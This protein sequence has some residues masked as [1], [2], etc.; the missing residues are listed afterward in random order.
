[1]LKKI[2]LLVAFTLQIVA[3][4]AQTVLRGGINDADTGEPLIGANLLVVGTGDGAVTDF[5]GQFELR[6][7][8]AFPFKLEIS[9]LGYTTQIIDVVNE[10]Q[11]NLTLAEDIETIGTVEITGQRIGEKQKASPRTVEQLDAIAIKQT[12]ASSFYDGLGALKGVDMT[13]ASLGFKVINTRGFNSTSPVRSLQIIDGVDNQAPGLNFSLGNFLGSSE[14]DVQSVDIIVGANSALYGPNAFNGVISITTKDPFYQQ[15]LSGMVKVAERNLF[16]AAVRF[17]DV[18]DNKDELPMIGYKLNFEYLRADDWVADNFDPVFDTNTDRTNPGGY[19]AVNIYGDEYRA[20]FDDSDSQPW[21]RPGL[22]Q[23]HR[24]GYREQDLVNYDTRNLKT[25][26]AVHFRLRPEQDFESPE[27]IA[28]AN[29]SNGTT[30]YQGDNRFS[31]Q[32]I[33]FF[34]SRLEL[35]KRD[36]YFVRA[37]YTVDDAGESFD[38][39]FT[40]LRLQQIAKSDRNWARDYSNYWTSEAEPEIRG[41]REPRFPLVGDY[42]ELEIIFEDG[43]VITSFDYDA[44][45][46]WLAMNNGSLALYHDQAEAAANSE[47]ANGDAF[48]EPD[49]E[50]FQMIFDSITGNLNNFEEMGTRF[51]DQSALYHTQGEYTF[52]PEWLDY[53][54]IGGNTRLYTPDS[55]GTVFSDTLDAEGNRT[56]ISVFEFGLYTGIEKKFADDKF[57]FSG[58]FRMDKNENFDAVFSPAASVVFKPKPN[59]YARLSFSS[60]VRNPTLADQYLLL[61]VGRATL[62]GNLTGVQDLVTVESFE[63][64]LEMP[65]TRRSQL[66]SFNIAPIQPEKVRTLELGYRTTIANRLFLDA[67]YYYSEYRDFLG[68]NIGVRVAF[69]ETTGNLSNARAFRYA[70]NSLNKVTTQGFS[71]GANY[72]FWDKYQFAANYSFNKLNDELDDPIIPAF[73]TPENKYN[74]GISGRDIEIG[75]IERVGF[76]VNYKWVEGFLFEGSPQFTGFVP[77]YGLL[78]AQI[79]YT[80]KKPNLTFKLGASN[81]LDNLHFEAYGGPRIGRLAYFSVTYESQQ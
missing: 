42:P 26:A 15:G 50:R 27:L 21:V 71:I 22:N 61:N 43:M 75:G 38:P 69:D 25:A 45:E 67:S 74:I 17:A 4:Q 20:A 14:L 52:N 56:E 16:N 12:A 31:L 10:A 78:D 39:Y 2:T 34:Q 58:T 6:T 11:L 13:S 32:G 44:A 65:S 9:Y 76:N 29:F 77:A 72:Y 64:F 59:N 47:T 51:F 23:F 60:A 5:D 48:Y 79:N 62:A 33:S 3:L 41:N 18:I 55:R 1:M 7:K 80:L 35:R 40:A 68:F 66:D 57:T 53:I 70:A 81:L 37:Y 24:T 54:K 63:E 46:A 36:K 28:A 8:Q 73:N 30:V 19:D 49:T